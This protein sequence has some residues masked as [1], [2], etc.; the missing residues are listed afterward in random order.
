MA[1]R[2]KATNKGGG[3]DFPRAPAGNHPACLVAIV[4]LGT[5]KTR[6]FQSEGFEEI[7]KVFLCWEL[8]TETVP[9]TKDN[10]LIGRDYRVSY[11]EKAALRLMMEGWRGRGYGDGDEIDVGATLG[12]KCLLNVKH[13]PGKSDPKKSFPNIEGVSAL[14]K[15]MKAP[16]PQHK[17]V[18]FELGEQELHELPEWVAN[19]FHYG[20]SIKEWVEDSKEWKHQPA[21]EEE[22]A[23]GLAH[24]DSY[25]PAGA[26]ADE[27][28]IPF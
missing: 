19:Y 3:E 28:E 7:H 26:E 6:K 13:K 16:D 17:P 24:G 21:E 23:P 27:G 22:L 1:F 2:G 8:L 12:F 9:G 18:S 14:P 25:E 15:G 11:A 5:Q 4:D 10:F 20:Q